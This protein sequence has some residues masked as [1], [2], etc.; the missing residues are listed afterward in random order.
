MEKALFLI[1]DCVPQRVLAF[2]G[3][4]KTMGLA[5]KWVWGGAAASWLLSPVSASSPKSEV[6]SLCC[7]PSSS[8]SGLQKSGFCT[9]IGAYMFLNNIPRL[10]QFLRLDMKVYGDN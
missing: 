2:L 3:S 7:L 10:L 8:E 1:C 9:P 5:W 6:S 4:K